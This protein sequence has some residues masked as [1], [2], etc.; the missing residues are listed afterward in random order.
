MDESLTADAS[1]Y[2]QSSQSST[3]TS[4]ANGVS[5]TS[6]FS[7]HA[8]ED[9]ANDAEYYSDM[10]LLVPG[11][12]EDIGIYITLELPNLGRVHQHTLCEV[13]LHPLHLRFRR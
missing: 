3:S 10:P 6:R 8:Y 13:R 11:E 4:S 12:L 9:V 1:A 2:H 5:V 7:A